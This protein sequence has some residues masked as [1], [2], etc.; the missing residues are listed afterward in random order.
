[1][2]AGGCIEQGVAEQRVIRSCIDIYQICVILD[3]CDDIRMD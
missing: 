3:E 1:M 2:S